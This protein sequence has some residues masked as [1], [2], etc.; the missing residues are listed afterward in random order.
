MVVVFKGRVIYETGCSPALFSLGMLMWI[1]F[2]HVVCD[3][4]CLD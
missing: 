4:L 3:N 1:E 2:V